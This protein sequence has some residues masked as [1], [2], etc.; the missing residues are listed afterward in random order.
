MNNDILVAYQA[1]LSNCGVIALSSWCTELSIMS[2]T[3]TV[4][5]YDRLPHLAA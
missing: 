4:T 1:A 2:E 3:A 5:R